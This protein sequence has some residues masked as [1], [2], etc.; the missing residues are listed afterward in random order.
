MLRYVITLLSLIVG[1]LPSAA[2]AEEVVNAYRRPNAIL[3]YSVIAFVL[4]YGLHD[5]FRTKWVT[6][7]GVVVLPLLFYMLLPSQ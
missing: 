6:W 2:W 5:T 3:Y 1:F 4:I 7:T